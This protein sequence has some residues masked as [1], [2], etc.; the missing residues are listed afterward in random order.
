MLQCWSR[1]PEIRPTFTEVCRKMEE[2][3]E[4]SNNTQSAFSGPYIYRVP[5]GASTIRMFFPS[6][7][8][9]VLTA[10]FSHIF[11]IKCGSLAKQPE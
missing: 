4:A 11:L 6:I 10:S 5:L 2:F 3:V 9:H 7:M 1:F 8:I